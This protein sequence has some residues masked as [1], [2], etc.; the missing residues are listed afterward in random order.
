[1]PWLHPFF[2][3]ENDSVY[4][5][6]QNTDSRQNGIAPPEIQL[7]HI[8]EVHSVPAYNQR[9]RHKDSYNGGKYRHYVVLLDS[10]VQLVKISDLHRVFS[11]TCRC[12]E[13]PLDLV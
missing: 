7:G 1:M 8:S 11:D 9:P 4:Y 13:K 6:Y 10:K 3:F 2:L 12:I 5:Y